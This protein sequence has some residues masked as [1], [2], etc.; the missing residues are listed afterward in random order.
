MICNLKSSARHP[1]SFKQTSG[2][3]KTVFCQLPWSYIMMLNCQKYFKNCHLWLSLWDW[4]VCL[5]HFKNFLRIDFQFLYST[6]YPFKRLSRQGLE[7]NEV[8]LFSL[9]LLCVS[10]NPF[11]LEKRRF[12]IMVTS[13]EV[14]VTPRPPPLP[15]RRTAPHSLKFTQFTRLFG[16]V[17]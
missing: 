4:S 7:I 16:L 12:E 5:F 11:Y 15:R 9:S 13:H 6:C 17:K 2:S 3:C 8:S 1:L 10:F 14:I